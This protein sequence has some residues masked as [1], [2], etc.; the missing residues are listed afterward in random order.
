VTSALADPD[1]YVREA[2]VWVVTQ[3]RTQASVFASQLSRS[4]SDQDPL[5]R[6]LAALALRNAGSSALP[7]LNALVAALK[8]TDA[9]V[10]MMSAD[11]IA[12]QGK[13]GLPALSALIEA[14]QVEGEQVP[15]LRNVA[16]ALGAIGP[17]AAPAL[18]V[19]KKLQVHPRIRWSAEA[20]MRQITGKL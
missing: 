4:L 8:D 18:P 10:R 17:E 9:N 6:G 15:V 11:A 7:F 5:V 13:S 1:P 19:L 16:A 12:R 14:G 2:A 20:A 3:M